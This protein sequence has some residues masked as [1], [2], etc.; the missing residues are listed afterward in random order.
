MVS[1]LDS[2]EQVVWVRAL[3]GDAV[4]LGKTRYSHTFFIFL[5]YTAFYMHRKHRLLNLYTLLLLAYIDRMIALQQS[6]A[7][8]NG[9]RA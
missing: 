5:P 4:F 8:Q 2:R 1:A 7:H 6:N 9:G 3:P